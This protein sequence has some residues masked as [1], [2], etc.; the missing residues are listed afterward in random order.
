MA[1][2]GGTIGHT[3]TGMGL[4]S[5][6]I[7]IVNPGAP[8]PYDFSYVDI[9]AAPSTQSFTIRNGGGTPIDAPVA[10]IT[11]GSGVF[12]VPVA[13]NSCSAQ[14]AGGATCV[15]TVEFDPNTIG[16]VT[17]GLQ[18]SS[19]SGGND[20]LGMNGTGM[21][22]ISTVSTG[23]GLTLGG[24]TSNQVATDGVPLAGHA[25]RDDHLGRVLAGELLLHLPPRHG[26]DPGH[27]VVLHDVER[28]AAGTCSTDAMDQ[29]HCTMDAALQI[30]ASSP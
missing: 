1:T 9:Q 11:A 17:G 12:S 27:R 19:T 22:A 10:S 18:V 8:A 16:Q 13:G 3:L 5:G 20:T 26:G 6:S 28:F 23:S 29:L 7:R 4:A 30:S 25:G 24:I 15:V 21:V 2:P 14:L